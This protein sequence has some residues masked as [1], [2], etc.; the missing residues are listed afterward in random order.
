M[1]AHAFPQPFV[2]HEQGKQ[3]GICTRTQAPTVVGIEVR[4]HLEKNNKTKYPYNAYTTEHTGKLGA[5][6]ELYIYQM[7]LTL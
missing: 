6:F 1:Q 4:Q 5:D 3:K 2:F 7:K